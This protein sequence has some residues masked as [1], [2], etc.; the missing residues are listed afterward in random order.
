MNPPF[1]EIQAICCL[2]R[3]HC[4]TCSH[5]HTIFIKEHLRKF[6][7]SSSLFSF[8]LVPNH[9]FLIFLSYYLQLHTHAFFVAAARHC[10]DWTF[11]SIK[12]TNLTWCCHA[13]QCQF[14][15]FTLEPWIQFLKRFARSYKIAPKSRFFSVKTSLSCCKTN[16][17]TNFIHC[18]I[19]IFIIFI[20]FATIYSSFFYSKSSPFTSYPNTNTTTSLS[21]TPI[22]TSHSML[23]FTSTICI[24]KARI[25][26]RISAY[27][28]SPSHYWCQGFLL[29]LV[30]SKTLLCIWY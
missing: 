7:F 21:K 13:Y 12:P 17:T 16:I 14:S 4:F 20:I 29:G 23:K 18:F 9:F 24:Q 22:T 5:T 30:W 28:F 3:R 11:A 19:I 1:T 10:F 8:T 6:P 25:Q 2:D 26:W 15:S 27:T